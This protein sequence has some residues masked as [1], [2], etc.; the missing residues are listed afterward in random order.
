M[1]LLPAALLAQDPAKLLPVTH[2]AD[3][4]WT[5]HNVSTKPISVYFVHYNADAMRAGINVAPWLREGW[6]Q[7]DAPIAP[8]ATVNVLAKPEVFA[9]HVVAII[10]GDGTVAG[11]AR[12]V[13]GLDLVELIFRR[14]AIEVATLKEYL[15]LDAAGVE[16]RLATER[17]GG[18]YEDQAR[19]A[20]V[21]LVRRLDRAALQKRLAFIEP[22][23]ARRV[24]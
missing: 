22:S 15:A 6:G 23:S 1:L 2:H 17:D 14:R 4:K 3:G 19:Q 21:D 13:D 20:A 9:V 10:F 8:G 11:E 5:A 24:R 18:T 12:T 16:A 7:D